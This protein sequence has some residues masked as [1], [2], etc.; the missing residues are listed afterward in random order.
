MNESPKQAQRES[1]ILRVLWMLVFLLVWQVAQFLLG[2]LVVVQ[3]WAA[4]VRS[5]FT[6]SAV[7]CKPAQVCWHRSVYEACQGL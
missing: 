4:C 1:I 7:R 2:A 5:T 3:S 6:T